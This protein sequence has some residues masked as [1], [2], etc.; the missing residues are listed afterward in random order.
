MPCMKAK[1]LPWYMPSKSGKH[2]LIGSKVLAYTDNVAI[3]YWKTVQNLSAV[4]VRWLVYIGMFDLDI[5]Y[6]GHPLTTS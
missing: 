3:R 6:F 4:Q 2:Y 5:F 1:C